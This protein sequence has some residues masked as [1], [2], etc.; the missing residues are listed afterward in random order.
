MPKR[1]LPQWMV[2]LQCDERFVYQPP[3]LRS[4]CCAK[5]LRD[6]LANGPEAEYIFKIMG[7]ERVKILTDDY[8]NGDANGYI[9][10]YKY[11]NGVPPIIERNM[12]HA[13]G[14]STY[15]IVDKSQ[16]NYAIELETEAEKKLLLNKVKK[17]LFSD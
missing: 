3:T 9:W 5:I 7:S 13:W 4:M 11:A 16:V 8:T 10:H 17:R 1:K 12:Q 14:H 15:D 2:K 6:N